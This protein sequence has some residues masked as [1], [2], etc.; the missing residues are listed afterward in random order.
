MSRDLI[1][2][3]DE[4]GSYARVEQWV[5]TAA[6]DWDIPT[7]FELSCGHTVPLRA[8]NDRR[9]AEDDE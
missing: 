1:T 5:F 3:C 6:T 7:D 8:P 2:L 4:C 9:G